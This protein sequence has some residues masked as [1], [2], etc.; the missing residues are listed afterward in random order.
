MNSEGNAR[1]KWS[2]EENEIL[3]QM[4]NKHGMKNWQTIAHAIPGRS[5]QQCR[6]RWRYKV[7][8]AINKEAWSQQEELRLIRAHQIYGTKWR[9]M[10]KHFPGRTNGALKDYWRGPMK[11]K[12]DSYL[13]SGL[14]EQL[15]DV[16]ENM[17]VP[18]N[19]DSDILNETEGLFD[20][21]ELPSGQ[22]TSSKSKPVL[23]E[24]GESADMSE[25]KNADFMYVRAVDAHSANAPQKIIVRS[26]QHARTRRKLD[27]LSSPV[28]LKVSTVAVNSE[29]PL[30]KKEQMGPAVSG[31]DPSNGCLDIS[32]EVPSQYANTLVSPNGSYQPNDVHSAGTS[33]PC[34]PEL[35][36]SDL[37]EM[38]YFDS[39][40]IFPPDSP[41]DG[42]SL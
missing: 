24:R 23:T 42:N 33:D 34:S 5:A 14:L 11:R 10:V 17:S 8:S 39:F 18:Q 9:E 32:P 13:A 15:P 38:S 1:V 31:I 41:H 16:L 19:S 21:N 29:R 37:M 27:I 36:I 35:D 22:P 40:M 26:E 3:T 12:L 20:R 30:Q 25:G 4:V 6:Q 28:E 2:E 7:D